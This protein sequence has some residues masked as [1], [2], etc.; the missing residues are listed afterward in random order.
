MIGTPGAYSASQQSIPQK[1][2]KPKGL[3][4]APKSAPFFLTTTK[5]LVPK[6]VVEEKEE[7]GAEKMKPVR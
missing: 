4:T 5:E 6:F 3:P 7:E 2:N 1:R